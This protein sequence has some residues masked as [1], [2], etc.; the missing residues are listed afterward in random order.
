M[1]ISNT[2]AAIHKLSFTKEE[3]YDATGGL[4]TRTLTVLLW[5]EVETEVVIAWRRLPWNIW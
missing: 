1:F 5:A 4:N 2:P 3:N